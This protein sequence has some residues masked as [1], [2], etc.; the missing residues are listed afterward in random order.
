MSLHLFHILKG[1]DVSAGIS[2]AETSKNTFLVGE[3]KAN[4]AIL[5]VS[6]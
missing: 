6:V 3:S 2:T 5:L 1:C 4:P